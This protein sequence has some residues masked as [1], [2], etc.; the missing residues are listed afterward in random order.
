V[1]PGRIAGKTTCGTFATGG[2][3]D[4]RRFLLRLVELLA[5]PAAPCGRRAGAS[6]TAVRAG[7]PSGAKT[8]WMP[9]AKSH[10]PIGA[11]GP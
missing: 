9:C 3:E 10:S 5:A 1:I 6:R 11:F 7:C 2:A 8:M 4:A